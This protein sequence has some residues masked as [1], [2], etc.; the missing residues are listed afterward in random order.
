MD[1]LLV[2]G[3]AKGNQNDPSDPVDPILDLLGLND[4]RV[5]SRIY[6]AW[7]AASVGRFRP[8]PEDVDRM[9][10]AIAGIPRVDPMRYDILFNHETREWVI[11]KWVPEDEPYGYLTSKLFLIETVE[12]PVEVYEIDARRRS[13][14]TLS[15]R[16]WFHLRANCITLVGPAELDRRMKETQA[17]IKKDRELKRQ[18]REHDFLGYYQKLFQRIGEETGLANATPQEMAAKFGGKAADWN[19]DFI[20]GIPR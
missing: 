18:D 4:V 17:Q 14:S 16:D 13:P 20:P 15:E 1:D 6:P 7:Y 12:R 8:N 5:G 10:R 3:A 11:V 9:R 19:P 2:R